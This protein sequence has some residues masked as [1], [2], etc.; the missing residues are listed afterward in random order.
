ME[1][2]E[3]AVA[4]ESL[5]LLAVEQGEQRARPGSKRRELA[6]RGCAPGCSRGRGGTGKKE[7]VRERRKEKRV[8]AGNF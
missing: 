5:L 1:A 7:A 8:A 3:L 2:G 4:V 6:G